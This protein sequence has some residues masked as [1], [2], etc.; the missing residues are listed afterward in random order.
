MLLNQAP[1]GDRCSIG[2]VRPYST[3]LLASSSVDQFTTAELEPT[4]LTVTAEMRRVGIRPGPGRELVGPMSHPAP[5]GRATP[6]N[7]RLLRQAAP[8]DRWRDSR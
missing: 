1:I 5:C 3:R 7:P 6:G 2:R 8:R 4:E